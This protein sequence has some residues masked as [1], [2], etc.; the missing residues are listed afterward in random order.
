M[1][2]ASEGAAIRAET[3]DSRLFESSRNYHCSVMMSPMYGD[4]I[5]LLNARNVRRNGA[6]ARCCSD[7]RGS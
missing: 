1:K 2:N 4:N 3:L 7:A 5:E 6:V